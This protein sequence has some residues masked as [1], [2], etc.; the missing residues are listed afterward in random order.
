MLVFCEGAPPS[1]SFEMSRPVEHVQIV[2]VDDARQRRRFLRLP[3]SV[4]AG[5]PAWVPPLLIERREHLSDRNPYF[6]HARC[7]LWLAYRGAIPVGRISAQIDAL[8]DAR[9]RDGTGFFG[10]LEAEDDGETFAALLGTAE[11]WL[12][13]QGRS[14][15]LGPFNFSIN[16]ECGMLVE[17]FETPPMIMMGH[18]RPYYEPR[19]V[20]QGYRPVKDLLA[21]RVPA[22]FKTPELMRLAVAKAAGSVHIRP[23]RKTRFQ[24]DLKILKDIFEDAWA[25]NWGF[26]PFT[27]DEF[28]H[29]GQSLRLLVDEEF[30][31]I[32]EVDGEPAAMIVVF[33]NVN[34]ALRDLDGRLFPFGW[35]RLWW[36]VKIRGPSTAR[37]PLMGVRKRFQGGALGSAL[38]FMLIDAVRRHGV[39][40]GVRDVELSWILEDNL[41]M[42]NMLTAIGGEPY[43]RYRLYEKTLP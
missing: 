39:R 33:P 43:K 21:Y 5:D 25:Q 22:D 32:A 34:E 37:V 6:A 24:E 35:L 28:R 16:Q 7:R 19:V 4:Y 15:I 2:S 30:I 41:P 12:R 38:A 8:Y 23:M 1:R 36:R 26:V 20:A 11:A 40:R 18:A 17:G 10:M 42:R 31:Q 3:W 13:E 29:V 14:R 27:D 9:Y